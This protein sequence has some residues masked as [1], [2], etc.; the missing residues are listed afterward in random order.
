MSIFHLSCI[1][2][3]ASLLCLLYTYVRVCTYMYFVYIQYLR[4]RYR[5]SSRLNVLDLRLVT[6]C[7]DPPRMVLRVLG[8]PPGILCSPRVDCI[9]SWPIEYGPCGAGARASPP[10]RCARCTILCLL[11]RLPYCLATVFTANPATRCATYRIAIPATG[12]A[13]R[14]RPLFRLR[15]HQQQ[16]P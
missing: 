13:I 15:P 3:K 11:V 14:S 16:W 5:S 6:R 4:P 9:I 7:A 1:S 10:L 12:P 2:N 8:V